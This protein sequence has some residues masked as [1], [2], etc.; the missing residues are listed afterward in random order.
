MYLTES[1]SKGWDQTTQVLIPTLTQQPLNVCAL[2][3][4]TWSVLLHLLIIIIVLR[5]V[6]RELTHVSAAA[7]AVHK[8]R[9]MRW[10]S[11]S[12]AICGCDA[13]PQQHGSMD[14]YKQVG[15]DAAIIV[16]QTALLGGV[17]L[18]S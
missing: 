12:R 10:P 15:F 11:L 2:T 9:W 1:E 8:M 6:L 4:E 3:L 16:L 17:T 14:Y 13:D 7:H 5:A 18:R